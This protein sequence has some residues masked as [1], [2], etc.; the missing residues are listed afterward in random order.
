MGL[1]TEEDWRGVFLEGQ[2]VDASEVEKNLDS[3]T[4]GLKGASKGRND[5]NHDT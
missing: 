3:L 1:P 5:G 2:P 4:Q